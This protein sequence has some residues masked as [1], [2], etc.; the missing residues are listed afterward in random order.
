MHTYGQAAYVRSVHPY[1]QTS[2]HACMRTHKACILVLLVH[3]FFFH[4]FMGFARVPI[5]VVELQKS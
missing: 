5:L 3:T 2:I 1:I 4:R